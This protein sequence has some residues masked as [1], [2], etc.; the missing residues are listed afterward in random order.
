MMPWRRHP[1]ILLLVPGLIIGCASRTTEISADG[2]AADEAT[3]SMSE[4]IVDITGGWETERYVRLSG[5]VFANIPGE[6]QRESWS[7]R[8]Q[9]DCP[10]RD[11]IYRL[12]S[13]PLETEGSEIV[14]ELRPEGDGWLASTDWMSSCVDADTRQVTVAEASMVHGVYVVRLGEEEDQPMLAISFTWEG[15]P[16]PAALAADCLIRAAEF[17]TRAR[18]TGS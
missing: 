9:S 10:G 3:S 1:W 14:M 17:E 5:D 16:T 11:C 8:P 18:R 7:I 6:L 2:S 15:E 12:G 13:T 4:S